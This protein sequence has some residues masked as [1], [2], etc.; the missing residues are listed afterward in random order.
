MLLG[1]LAGGDRLR[2]G[3]LRRLFPSFP[4]GDCGERGRLFD[5]RSGVDAAV[6]LE[7]SEIP[8]LLEFGV[9]GAS[10]G[11]G[12]MRSGESSVSKYS[13][14]RFN[15]LALYRNISSIIA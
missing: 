12:V 6:Q 7:M 14:L 5:P 2:D 9:P 13:C 3:E 8:E 11:G 1:S 10:L 4:K 15:E